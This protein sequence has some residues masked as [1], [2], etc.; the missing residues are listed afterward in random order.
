MPPGWF[1]LTSFRV[2]ASGT[3]SVTLLLPAPAGAYRYVDISLQAVG[4]GAAHSADSVLRG[5]TS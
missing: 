4:A 2:G 5:P 3:A 1:P